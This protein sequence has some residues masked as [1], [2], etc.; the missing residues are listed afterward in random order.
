MEWIFL[1]IAVSQ[2]RFQEG[3]YKGFI[4]EEPELNVI[5][6]SRP[7]MISIVQGVVSLPVTNDPLEEAFF[8]IRNNKG[9]VLTA[10]TDAFGKFKI[11]NVP[12]GSYD[13]K[14]TKNGFMSVIG[15]IKISKKYSRKKTIHIQLDLGT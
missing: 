1:G 3:F 4:K 11:T 8:E 14:V 7:F 12:E 9:Q 13:F 5:E 2:Q 10:K 6:Y 15:K